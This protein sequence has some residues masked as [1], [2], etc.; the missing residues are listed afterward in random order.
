MHKMPNMSKIGSFL[1]PQGSKTAF[2]VKNPPPQT[3]YLKGPKV[4]NRSKIPQKITQK[5][6]KKPPFFIKKWTFLAKNDP[7]LT[8]HL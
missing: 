1:T 2:R 6:V 3:A 5:P 4:K 8:K 7:F